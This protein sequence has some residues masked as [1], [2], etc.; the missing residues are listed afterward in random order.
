MRNILL[1]ATTVICSLQL[2]AQ[3]NYKNLSLPSDENASRFTFGNMRIY[4]VYANANF[5]S[6]QKNAGKY[7]TLK[8][9]LQKKKATITE[10]SAD[11]RNSAEV[12][13]L[14]IQ[15]TSSDT[16]VIIGGEV[17]QG[18]KQ[19]RVIANDVVIPPNSGKVDLSVYCVEHGRWTPKASGAASYSFSTGNNTTVVNTKTRKAAAVEKDQGKVWKEVEV[20][21]DKNGAKSSTGAFTAMETKTDANKKLT[22]YKA[23]F[24]TILTAD[25]K[26]I[27]MAVATGDSVLGCDMF[28]THALLME[29]ADN[30]IA[31]YAIEAMTDGKP[32]T[33]PFAKVKAYMDNILADETKQEQHIKKN[34]TVLQEKESKLHISVY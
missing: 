13:K 28:A 25:V 20:F 34:G 10:K 14:Y 4:P 7:T 12:N 26:I 32:V 11:G 33:I 21:T 9:A 29:H 17:V 19:D 24:K 8:D 5:T 27:G 22:A 2:N 18:G 15:N 23:Y 1:F 31:S 6:A 3:Y 30:I 16:I